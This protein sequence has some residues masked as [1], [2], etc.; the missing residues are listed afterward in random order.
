[1][2]PLA[3]ERTCQEREAELRTVLGDLSTQLGVAAEATAD[4]A[5][6]KH[7]P[8]FA[9]QLEQPAKMLADLRGTANAAAIKAAWNEA[10]EVL[11][12]WDAALQD[13]LSAGGIGLSRGYALGRALADVYWGLVPAVPAVA[14]PPQP[15]TSWEFLLGA[16]RVE[17]IDTSLR[18]IEPM[19]Y[20]TT[21][22]AIS[23]TVHAWA[24]LVERGK[25]CDVC[26]PTDEP[27][28]KLGAQLHWWHE[29][30]VTGVDPETLLK[31]YAG[32]PSHE[33]SWKALR[34]FAPEALIG[35]GGFLSLFG[36]ALATTLLHGTG[37]VKVILG[38]LGVIGLSIGAV[39]AALKNA[40]QSLFGRMRM[41][42]Y[43]DLVI[44]AITE[45]P[46]EVT[47]TECL[48]LAVR[49][50]AESRPVTSSLPRD[51]PPLGQ[52]QNT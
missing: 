48:G 22:P 46:A 4:G 21:A 23:A 8:P 25:I 20:P 51:R 47:R 24:V 36:L 13:T 15:N 7:G 34:R 42:L 37:W 32:Q 33:I 39:Q 12:R 35:L 2:L 9:T 49:S 6:R 27:M 43:A 1:M 19:Y 14:A 11:F 30:L 16:E 17:L 38:A 26:G 31:P 40:A 10:G 28:T 44:T 45:L 29:L 50:A 5:T 18:T 52:L 41:D 3:S